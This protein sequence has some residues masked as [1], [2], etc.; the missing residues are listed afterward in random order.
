MEKC[1]DELLADGADPDILN[2]QGETMLAYA[3]KHKKIKC[4]E[5]LLKAGADINKPCTDGKTAL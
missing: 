2:I 3:A 1:F 5:K 4:F